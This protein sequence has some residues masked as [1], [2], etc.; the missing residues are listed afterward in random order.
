MAFIIL[1]TQHLSR[2]PERMCQLIMFILLSL[3]LTI[4]LGGKN[5]DTLGHLGGF[6]TGVFV[7]FWLMPCVEKENDR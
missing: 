7:G 5:V 6:L 1:N 3:L 2:N 4:M